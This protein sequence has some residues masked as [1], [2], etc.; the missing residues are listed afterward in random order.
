[1]RKYEIMMIISPELDER[2]VT[3][4]RVEKYLELITNNGGSVDEFDLWGGK[5]RLATEINKKTEGIYVVLKLTSTPAD[6]QELNRQFG[7]NEQIMRTKVFLLD[8]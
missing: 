1:M 6:V 5:R 8:K 4:P 3:P 7:I 2:Q